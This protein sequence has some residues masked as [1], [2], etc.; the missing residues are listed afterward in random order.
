M[1]LPWEPHPALLFNKL[2]MSS[3]LHGELKIIVQTN[4]TI[5]SLKY[6]GKRQRWRFSILP[7]LNWWQSNKGFISYRTQN[8]VGECA[9][10]GRP[11]FDK[12]PSVNSSFL[13][14]LQLMFKQ[15]FVFVFYSVLFLASR[16]SYLDLDCLH[17]NKVYWMSCK[18]LGLSLT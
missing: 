7:E 8:K 13:P 5:T 4:I 12:L 14:L 9:Q 6:R 3:K 16:L 10:S 15:I 11:F 17:K 2:I 1:E 18:I